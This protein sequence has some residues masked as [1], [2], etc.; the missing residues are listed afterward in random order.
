M[1]KVLAAFAIIFISFFLFNAG[2]KASL[3]RYDEMALSLIEASFFLTLSLVI[4]ADEW[5]SAIGEAKAKGSAATTEVL[6][7]VFQKT[8]NELFEGSYP[9][10]TQGSTQGPQDSVNGIDPVE[11][12]RTQIPVKDETDKP[13]KPLTKSQQRRINAKKGL[14]PITDE[15]LREQKKEKRRAARAAK[16]LEESKLEQTKLI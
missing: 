10:K 2:F 16:K 11:P 1:K 14:G 13:V 8:F 7:K 15:E 3:H 6:S 12:N 4:V 5:N 9:V